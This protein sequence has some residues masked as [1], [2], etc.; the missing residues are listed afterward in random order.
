MNGIHGYLGQRRPAF[1]DGDGAQEVHARRE[2][3]RGEETATKNRAR[4]AD[5]ESQRCAYLYA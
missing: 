4:E 1:L 2:E 5:R 3:G